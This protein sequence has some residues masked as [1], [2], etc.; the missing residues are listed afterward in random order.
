MSTFAWAMTAFVVLDLTVALVVVRSFTKSMFGRI[1]ETF[2]PV[3]PGAIEH[4]RR[5]QS[6]SMG[7]VNFGFSVRVRVDDRFVHISPEPW[8][9]W[10][11]M[12][13]ASIPIEE[14]RPAGTERR[15]WLA[16]TFLIDSDRLNQELRGPGWLWHLLRARQSELV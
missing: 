8:V 4:E 2:P 9:F 12:P 16:H 1:A 5:A 15:S 10:A 11:G 13:S 14:L 3:E 7:I 6:F